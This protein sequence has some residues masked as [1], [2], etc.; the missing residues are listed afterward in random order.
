MVALSYPLPQT[1][2]NRALVDCLGSS[3]TNLVTGRRYDNPTNLDAALAMASAMTRNGVNLMLP[4]TVEQLIQGCVK[5]NEFGEALVL[6]RV[7]I[8]D[9]GVTPPLRLLAGICGSIL[10]TPPSTVG[11]KEESTNMGALAQVFAQFDTDGDGSI[12]LDELRLGLNKAL[13]MNLPESRVAQLMSALD[14]D[15]SGTLEIGEFMSLGGLKSKLEEI[16]RED[17]VRKM[18]VKEPEIISA[19]YTEI[20]TLLTLTKAAGY[21][22]DTLGET[23]DG[24]VLLAG[25]L[26]AAQKIQNPS[27]G[28]RLLTAAA[29][30]E[31]SERSERALRPDLDHRE[32]PRRTKRCA[33][34]NLAQCSNLD[35]KNLHTLE[36]RSIQ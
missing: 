25:G 14:E 36:L 34:P 8:V 5:E 35:V 23:E 30:A 31:V 6:L 16:V 7:L 10:S 9:V 11:R 32:Q 15:S 19:H 18:R 22:L 3:Y 33:C 29:K 4:D 26:I 20:L 1:I 21:T 27:L 28:L 17:K 12:D 13:N 2:C 24:R